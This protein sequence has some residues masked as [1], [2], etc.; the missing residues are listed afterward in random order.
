[1]QELIRKITQQAKLHR[2][3]IENFSY[4]SLLQVFNMLLPLITYPYLIRVL[5]KET[6]GLIVLA[7]AII[8][9]LVIIVNFGFNISATKEIS[10]HREN[11]EK[12]NE[13]VSSV[14]AIKGVLFII[15]FIVLFIFLNFIPQAKEHQTLFYLTMWLCLYD[16]VFPIWYFQG[17]E[18][19]KYISF[20]TL[21]TRLL[22]LILIFVFVKSTEHY[23]RVPLFNGIGAALSG[24]ITLYIIY[25]KHGI[26]VKPVSLTLLYSYIKRSY[27]LFLT[28]AVTVIKDKTSYLFI[29]LFL[30]VG[31][32]AIF[33]L[34]VKIKNILFIPGQ[35]INQTI[36]PKMSKTKDMKFLKVIMYST[37]IFMIFIMLGGIFFSENIISFLGGSEMKEAVP[38]SRI[39]LITLPILSTSLFL[40][41]NCLI[42][43]NQYYIIL[44]GMIYTTLVYLALIGFI[45][46]FQLNLY[47][48]SYA[49]VMVITYLFEMFYRLVFS[50]KYLTIP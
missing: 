27:I 20:I 11:K 46:L 34:A 38:I 23:L 19:M 22:F 31:Q 18:K 15:S 37:I 26:R 30:G 29:G 3:L 42:I 36:F 44:K 43:F 1:V 5:G 24:V 41:R 33:D 2:T 10:I 16:F 17:I 39:V 35:I 45:V 28:D 12:V 32:V 6:Y 21:P 25:Y 40:A 9:Y 13:I 14:F 4:L 47:T 7:Q 48:I 49:I 50:R 8:S